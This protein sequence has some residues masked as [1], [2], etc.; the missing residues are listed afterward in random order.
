MTKT[1][2]MERKYP[3]RGLIVRERSGVEVSRWGCSQC[4]WFAFTPKVGPFGRTS[5]AARIAQVR[6]AFGK[7]D[8][9]N[10]KAQEVGG[11]R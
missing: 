9:K 11:K 3:T 7:H 6:M 8:C 2:D 10:Y 5:K 4:Y 1:V